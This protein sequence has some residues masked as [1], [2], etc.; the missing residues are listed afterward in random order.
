MGTV[1]DHR[2]TA[3]ALQG[4]ARIVVSKSRYIRRLGNYSLAAVPVLFNTAVHDTTDFSNVRKLSKM[5]LNIQRQTSSTTYGIFFYQVG[6]KPVNTPLSTID[7]PIVLSAT[8]DAVQ[9]PNVV[10][11]LMIGVDTF[12]STSG[13][14]DAI[15]VYNG[16]PHSLL[17]NG[18]LFWQSQVDPSAAE[19]VGEAAYIV[20]FDYILQ[21]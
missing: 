4:R 10:N 6:V 13:P 15:K 17:N 8:T 11:T 1:N 16:A 9:F 3:R 20:L 21:N 14:V 7:V 5:T 18:Q 12:N 19:A 2:L